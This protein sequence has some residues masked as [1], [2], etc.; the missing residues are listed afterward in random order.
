MKAKV[1]LLICYHKPD[2]L[3]QDEVLTPIHVGRALARQ[4][5]G[6]NDPDFRWMCEHMIGDD[7]GENISEK[8]ASYNELTALYWAWKNYDRLG[9]PDYIGLMHYRRHFIFRP[10]SDVVEEVD[11]IDATYFQRIH[12]NAE[13]M[14]HLFDDCDYVAHLGHVDNV[15]EHYRAN[16][17]IE[18]LDRALRILYARYPRYKK[19]AERF[20]RSSYGNFCNMFIFP[21]KIFFEYCSWLFDILGQFE[22]ETDLTDKRLFISE[23]LTGIYIENLKRRGLRQKSLAAT[24]VRSPMRIPLAVPYCSASIFRTAVTIL[25]ALRAAESGVSLALYVLH[26]E[27]ELKPGDRPFEAFKKRFPYCTIEYVNV[28]RQ[29]KSRGISPESFEFPRQYPLVLAP[30][31]PAENKVLYVDE[32]VLFQ[33]NV[34]KFFQACNADEFAAIGFKKPDGSI[35]ENMFVLQCARL[36]RL[37]VLEKCAKQADLS[38]A[39]DFARAIEDRVGEIPSYFGIA[40]EIYWHPDSRVR[41]VEEY[42]KSAFLYYPEQTHPWEAVAAPASVA[43]WET[44]KGIPSPIPFDCMSAR[45]VGKADRAADVLHGAS[46]GKMHAAQAAALSG[47]YFCTVSKQLFSKGIRYLRKYGMWITLKKT[48]AVMIGKNDAN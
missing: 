23:R 3:L 45:A 12:Y 22:R 30:L 9:D 26:R 17:H 8:N 35:A 32:H 29:L 46:E 20:L 24:F 15:Y 7:T 2:V 48:I 36:R 10:A 21:R 37:S 39:E 18:D 42:S 13:G 6:E 38:V 25:S 1:K 19:S 27:G 33:K 14:A 34:G 43:W 11:A 40:A 5:R 44:A 41:G 28:T 4:K 16:H 47:R 31:L